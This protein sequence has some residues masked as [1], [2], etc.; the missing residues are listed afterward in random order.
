MLLGFDGCPLE[1]LEIGLHRD[2]CHLVQ[3]TQDVV[4]D[5]LW[6]KRGYIAAEPSPDA[7]CA[8]H[9]NHRHNRNVVVWLYLLAIIHHI[10]QYWVVIGVKY[11]PGPRGES[12][13]DVPGAG[14]ILP[15]CQARPKL[16]A[17]LKQIQV[18]R[19]HKC[20]CKVHNSSLE[21]R[22]AVMVRRLLRHVASQLSHLHILCQVLLEASVNHLALTWLEPICHM[23]N[24]ALD[25][26]GAKVGQVLVHK[27]S[28]CE[29]FH[30]SVRDTL[31][32]YCHVLREPLFPVIGLCLTEC[33]CH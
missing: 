10:V 30:L 20:L 4:L 32:W 29:G 12:R 2:H 23:W 7:L 22:F 17:R 24:A 27:V 14:C 3:C 13:K 11:L 21:T 9:Q 8:I 31:G 33:E 15:P 26:L 25:V 18:V 28:Y 19:P 16:S 5:S 1:S 6:V